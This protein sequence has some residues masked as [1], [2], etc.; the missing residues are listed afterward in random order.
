VGPRAGLDEAENLVPN[1]I[2]SRTVQ[3][4]VR[5]SGFSTRP[6]YKG[7]VVEKVALGQVL[8]PA[9]RCSLATVIPPKLYARSTNYHRLS[10]GIGVKQRA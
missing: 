7:F 4:V 6:I 5:R 1:G 10:N 3:P 8:I 9:F 2:R